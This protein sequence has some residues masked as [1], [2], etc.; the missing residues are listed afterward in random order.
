MVVFDFAEDERN[1]GIDH[2]EADC[3]VFRDGAKT[4]CNCLVLCT[5]YRDMADEW[6]QKSRVFVGG[7]ELWS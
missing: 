7:D 5:G 3:V 1:Q 6:Y 4:P 2:V